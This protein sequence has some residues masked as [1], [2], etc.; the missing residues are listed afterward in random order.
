MAGIIILTSLPYQQARAF[1]W[2]DLWSR[3]DHQGAQ[4]LAA[5]KPEEAAERFTDPDWRGVAHYR[6]DQYEQAA[7]D[8]ARVDSGLSFYNRGNALAKLG[9]Y[10]AAVEAYDEALALDPDNADAEFNRDLIKELLAQ[11][12]SQDQGQSSPEQSQDEQDRAQQSNE[13]SQDGQDDDQQEQQSQ[14]DNEPQS[15]RSQDQPEQA[16]QGEQQQSPSSQQHEQQ[17]SQE[18]WLRRVPDDPGGL[19][20]QKFL[21]D[22]LRRQRG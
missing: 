1:D 21:R 17:Q 20:R 6:A 13:Q 22:H 10:Q 2:R 15:S 12:Q 3:P 18:Q 8:F 9:Q 11:Q 19:L 4:L 7:E 16:T 14:Q 5:D